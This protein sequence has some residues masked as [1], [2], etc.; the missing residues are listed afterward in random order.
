MAIMSSTGGTNSLHFTDNGGEP[1]G[2]W[3]GVETD[4]LTAFCTRNEIDRI[5]LVKC[6]A[7]GHDYHVLKGAIELF[8][9]NRI[10]VFQFEYNHRWVYARTFLKDVFDLV[11]GLP[12]RCGRLEPTS[13]ELFDE[14]HPELDRFFQSN[15]VLVSRQALP[16]F[17]T[18]DG[19]FDSS[20][21][22]A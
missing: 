18:H 14:W 15:Y 8:A 1:P 16:W 3:I 20:N 11:A 7:E 17:T 19:T 2:G 9:S 6:D 5:H 21:T 12:Y 4:T 22:Y 13:I 10:D